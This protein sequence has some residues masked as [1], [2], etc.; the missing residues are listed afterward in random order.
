MRTKTVS[1]RVGLEFYAR[2]KAEA[3]KRGVTV[4]DLVRKALER[5]LKPWWRFW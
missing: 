4:S 2:V 3:E 5:E 1:A